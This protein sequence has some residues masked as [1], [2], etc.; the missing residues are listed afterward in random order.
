MTPR[1]LRA[2][3]LDWWDR[4]RRQ[5]G[6]LLGAA[7]I[8]VL[9]AIGLTFVGETE[10]IEGNPCPTIAAT[11]PSVAAQVT[12]PTVEALRPPPVGSVATD[13]EWRMP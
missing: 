5:Y 10:L 8:A 9:L 13:C 3:L 7:T 2:D 12:D 4:T 11:S 6:P 1:H